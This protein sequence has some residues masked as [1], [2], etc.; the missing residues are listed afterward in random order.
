MPPITSALSNQTCSTWPKVLTNLDAECPI[1]LQLRH[2]RAGFG[3]SFISFSQIVALAASLH[4]TLQ[5]RFEG[6]VAGPWGAG[7]NASSFFGSYF[8]R[9]LPPG[10]TSMLV[11]RERLPFMVRKLR[12]ACREATTP[13]KPIILQVDKAPQCCQTSKFRGLCEWRR[14][15]AL[16]SPPAR[17]SLSRRARSELRVDVHIRRG[18]VIAGSH[19]ADHRKRLGSFQYSILMRAIPNTAYLNILRS[20]LRAILRYAPGISRCGATMS[21]CFC[22]LHTWSHLKVLFESWWQD[23]RGAPLRLVERI[24]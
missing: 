14:A 9:P 4:L 23:L 15:Y 20:G 12:R 7:A 10:P 1:L 16:H 11:S 17:D 2:Q 22:S 24:A 6:S 3:H 19:L 8:E 21:V 18:D 13:P 5:S